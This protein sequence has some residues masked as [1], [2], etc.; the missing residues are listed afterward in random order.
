M[1][2]YNSTQLARMLLEVECHGTLE[3]SL[4]RMMAIRLE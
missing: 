2:R 1:A 4:A 3:A